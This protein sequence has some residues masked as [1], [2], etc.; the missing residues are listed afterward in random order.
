MD[1]ERSELRLI[2]STIFQSDLLIKLEGNASGFHSR[3]EFRRV[4]AVRCD[5]AAFN[6]APHAH[7]GTHHSW[8][9]DVH[10]GRAEGVESW[11]CRAWLGPSVKR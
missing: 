5:H 2:I 4:E 10:H 9:G 8:Q 1:L 6:I 11:R 3:K 7:P